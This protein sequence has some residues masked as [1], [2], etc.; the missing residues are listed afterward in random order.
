M[1]ATPAEAD[2]YERLYAW[3]ARWAALEAKPEPGRLTSRQERIARRAIACNRQIL[4]LM[5][6]Y[7]ARVSN[8]MNPV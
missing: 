5:R 2:E 4:A 7:D 3:R 6:R 1:Q 8:T